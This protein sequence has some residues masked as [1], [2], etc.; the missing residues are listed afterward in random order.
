VA[1][2]CRW[3]DLCPAQQSQQAAGARGCS[4]VC[5]R[6]SLQQQLVQW[7]VGGRKRPTLRLCGSSS[8]CYP[9]CRQQQRLLLLPAQLHSPTPAGQLSMGGRLRLAQE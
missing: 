6:W 9:A 5:A 2:G 7:W 3:R 4:K 1:A 8:S